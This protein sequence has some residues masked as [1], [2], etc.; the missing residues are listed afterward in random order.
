M[1]VYYCTISIEN[2]MKRV[3]GILGWIW[4]A[5]AAKNSITPNGLLFP[6][7]LSSLRFKIINPLQDIE[8]ISIIIDLSDEHLNEHSTT[9]LWKRKAYI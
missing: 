2:L 4:V 1:V 6:L 8:L 7:L 5:A 9:N 3:L